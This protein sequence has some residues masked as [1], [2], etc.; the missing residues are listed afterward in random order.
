LP[1]P[2]LVCASRLEIRKRYKRKKKRKN[3]KEKEKKKKDM[4]DSVGCR[5]AV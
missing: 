4:D 5:V 1:T 2:P 3:K